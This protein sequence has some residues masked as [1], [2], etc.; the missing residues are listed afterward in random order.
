MDAH[1]STTAKVLAAIAAVGLIPFGLAVVGSLPASDAPRAVEP[2]ALS[3]P[4]YA[5]H[6]IAIETGTTSG[7]T[8]NGPD[9]RIGVLQSLAPAANCGV[10]LGTPQLITLAGSTGGTP[11]PRLAS[12]AS[13]SIGVK[14]KKSGTSCY[15]VNAV[16]T[17]SLRIGLGSGVTGTSGAIPGAVASSAYL[18]LE[19]KGG[20]RIVAT[21]RMGTTPVG[22]F[23]LRSGSLVG[24][25]PVTEGVTPFECTTAADSGA[26]SNVSDNC[27]WPISVPS[28]TPGGDDGIF[29]DS[30][31]LE[32][33]SGSFSLEGGADG[34]VLPAAPNSTPNASI[35]EIATDTLG[36]KASTP[37]EPAVDD[38]PSVSVY[39][40]DNADGS[41]CKLIPYALANGPG[42][43]Q[44][45]K[46]L[47]SQTSAQF[48]WEM[49]GPLA[50]PTAT[51]GLATG[52]EDITI[53]YETNPS[54]NPG[55]DLVTL[56][57]CP[58]ATYADGRFAGYT[59]EQMAAF[60]AAGLD[61]DEYPGMQYACVINR[62][63]T[64]VDG[65]PDDLL[66]VRDLV[67]V[68]GDATMRR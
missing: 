15:Q 1:R 6:W 41:A 28:W 30:L 44:F 68:F 29:F 59:D 9:G 58:D 20:V 43:A 10:N 31:T 62:T 4:A 33:L 21:A 38:E 40:L 66:Q 25:P 56:G 54:A 53:D 35:I 14:E 18:D 57:W 11:D 32:A 47:D 12:Y 19:L 36:C 52:L 8:L 13:G 22:T 2:A 39:R 45:L 3:T 16:T 7:V 49:N 60:E 65:T 27:R 17:E 67:Y 24:A 50:P 26:D 46:P 42:S 23:E 5:A 48:I 55:D 51:T 37:T 34:A 64:S 63:A 61:Q